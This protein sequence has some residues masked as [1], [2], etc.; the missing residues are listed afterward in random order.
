MGLFVFKFFYQ[1][2][3]CR[4]L[5]VYVIMVILIPFFCIT[6]YARPVFLPAN[7]D[8]IWSGLAPVPPNR[9]VL[10]VIRIFTRQLLMAQ[11]V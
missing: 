8:R 4:I 2:I 1:L 11:L 5:V 9:P 6:E 3:F 7:L 10:P